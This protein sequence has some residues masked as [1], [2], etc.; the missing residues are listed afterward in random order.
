MSVVHVV[1][2]A[3][4]PLYFRNA[5]NSVLRNTQDDV[6]AIYNSISKMD[7]PQ[8]GDLLEQAP[9]RLQVHERVNDRASRGKVGSLYEAYN[10]A[11]AVTLGE[12]NFVHFL[13]GD[14][15]MIEWSDLVEL[16]LI[17]IFRSEN[18]WCVNPVAYGRE[19][20]ETLTA[21]LSPGPTEGSLWWESRAMTDSGIYSLS[22]IEKTG[23]S[24]LESEASV[25]LR[26][27]EDGHTLVLLR[28]PLTCF[29]PWPGVVRNGK[30]LGR[31][32]SVPIDNSPLLVKID[33][34]TN[35]CA[36][37]VDGPFWRYAEDWVEPSGW[38]CLYPFSFTFLER[39]SQI[40]LR[41]KTCRSLGVSFFSV[42][43]DQRRNSG[44]WGGRDVH[45]Y[46]GPKLLLFFPFFFLRA[47]H[48]DRKQ[49]W[50]ALRRRL[51]MS[52]KPSN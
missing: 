9:D 34:A 1:V 32:P 26:L 4:F 49:Y 50:R 11:L 17:E 42:T 5:V 21:V 52:R 8:L 19:K 6:V 10:F 25:N 7:R 39:P 13:Q 31:E 38:S 22:K 40:A 28:E 24:F 14:M 44:G 51:L 20:E 37:K 45:P 30:R 2:G 48:R 29:V 15:Q 46:D 3:G 36:Q 27:S 12:Y 33:Q 18:V 23:F 47:V 16:E 43:G 35:V 41:L